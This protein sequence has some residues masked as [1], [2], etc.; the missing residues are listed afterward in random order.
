M[1]VG[2][3]LQHKISDVLHK[4]P[5]VLIDSLFPYIRSECCNNGE[6]PFE[7][8]KYYPYFRAYDR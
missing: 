5:L 1:Y 4:K 7:C 3:F 2:D 8:R 6:I